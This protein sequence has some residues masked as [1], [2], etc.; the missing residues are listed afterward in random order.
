[1]KPPLD[2][3]HTPPR[4]APCEHIAGNEKFALKALQIQELHL[5]AD[6]SSLVDITLDLED[7]APVGQ[8]EALRAQFVQLIQSEHNKRKQIGVRVHASTSPHFE[9]DIEEVASKAAETVAYITIPKVTSVREVTWVAGI[10]AHYAQRSS[11]QR[12]IPLHLLIET[13]E[14]LA[15]L[16]ELAA[17]PDVAT[18][19]F[20]LM[21]FIS[22][23]GG[24]IPAT[25]MKSPDQF[26]H[27]LL[28]KVKGEIAI[29]ALSNNKIP[30]HNVTV[31]VRNPDQ[32]F[33][34]AWRARHEFGFLR[35]WSIHPN[36]IAPI[37][38]GMTPTVDEVREA[39]EILAAA[40]AA[41]WGP[42]QHNG[43][44][45]DRASY[46]YYWGIVTQSG[47]TLKP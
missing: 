3:T 30:N 7:G 5:R 6:G 26:E 20:G 24:A 9:R 46:R 45:H 19:D 16:A 40:Q 35:M 29:A 44:L 1:M 2:I 36:Q 10:I 33:H 28:M 43:R 32:A 31:D 14:A 8:E 37:I 21:D 23:L 34:D 15:Q 41:Q 27:P 39:R 22:H 18:L 38:R 12:R 13:P 42:I 17:H 47:D 11:S 25:G 4:L